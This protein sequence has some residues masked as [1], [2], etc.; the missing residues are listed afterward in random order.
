MT[1]P[2][3]V[4]D[5]AVRYILYQRT[6]YQRVARWIC[7]DLLGRAFPRPRHWAIRLESRLRRSAVKSRYGE[8]MQREFHALRPHLPSTCR[9]VLDIG[10]GVAGIDALVSRFYEH[11]PELYLLDRTVIERS[12]FY[13]FREHG[14]FYNSLEVARDVLV[15]NGVDNSRIHLLEAGRDRPLAQS[16]DLALSLISWGFHYPVSTYLDA[17]WSALRPGGKVLLDIR[18]GTD[19]LAQLA[20][21]FSSIEVIMTTRKQSRV[22]AT[23]GEPAR[24]HP[25]GASD[26]RLQTAGRCRTCR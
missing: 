15:A 4:P 20:E 7:P 10:C 26:I 14:A 23:K 12:V 11:E 16:V 22:I 24:S 21:R 2:L 9:G 19:G 13:M 17:V 1:S 5:G 6:A 18:A 25:D 8:E 3:R